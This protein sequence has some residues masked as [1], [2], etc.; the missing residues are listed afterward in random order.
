MGSP[1]GVLLWGIVSIAIAQNHGWPRE[2][3]RE[4]SEDQSGFLVVLTG[5]LHID[6]T[7]AIGKYYHFVK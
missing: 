6:A 5:I 7:L 3:I 2:K 1:A 4:V